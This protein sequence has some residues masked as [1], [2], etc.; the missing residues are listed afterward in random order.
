[1]FDPT[2]PTGALASVTVDAPPTDVRPFF[3]DTV[4]LAA[5][6]AGEAA[7]PH[8]YAVLLTTLVLSTALSTGGLLMPLYRRSSRLSASVIPSGT[9][10]ALAIGFGFIAAEVVLLQ[11]LTLYLGQ[12]SLA[13]SVGLMALLAGAA[14]GSAV[15]ERLR[16]GTA[17]AALACAIA[18]AV[19]F[20]SLPLVTDATLAAPIVLRVLIGALATVFVGL[21]LG[22]VFPRLA[23][24]VAAVDPA[25]VSW[26]WA[27]NG[28][29]S[30]IGAVLGI[31]IALT[32]GFTALGITGVACYLLA[33]IAAQ[34]S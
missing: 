20:T 3:F 8:G 24:T 13:L 18:L 9:A 34:R 15:S 11:R 27:V 25:L 16:P 12:P 28:T 26:V 14:A 4:P 23:A 30:V 19:I 2:A 7:L 22:M 5:V 33:A 10:A 17:G 1:A 29:A 32:G 21:P 31:A 6:L